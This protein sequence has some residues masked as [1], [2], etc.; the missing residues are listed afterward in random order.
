MNFNDISCPCYQ[1]DER[2]PSCHSH[3]ESYSTWTIERKE[4]SEKIKRE[5]KKMGFG[6][7]WNSARW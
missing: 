2:H 7:R 5:Q 1:C 4:L 3:C 6:C